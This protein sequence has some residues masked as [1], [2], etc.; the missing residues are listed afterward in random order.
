M[1]EELVEIDR[2]L[3]EKIKLY[4]YYILIAIISIIALV[5]LPTL[6]SEGDIGFNFPQSSAGWAV[7][8]ATKLLCAML[9]VMI[10][11][12]FNEQGRL[13]V[14]ENEHY[15]EANRIL[16][17]INNKIKLPRSPKQWL[18][19]QYS[20]KGVLIFLSTLAGMF[21]IT[22]ALL[23][24]DWESLI[25]YVITIVIGIVVGILQMG[26]A[27]IYWTEEYYIYAKGKEQELND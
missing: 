4:T 23:K 20:R 22:N 11:Y 17:K 25:S 13:N 12:C 14:K 6:G 1:Q 24:W 9:N 16:L 27:E 8:I 19:Q 26:K 3:K 18:T 21:C 7:Y 2:T 10:F 5:F 15:K